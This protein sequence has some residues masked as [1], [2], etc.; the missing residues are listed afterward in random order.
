MPYLTANL[1]VVHL[2]KFLLELRTK[3]KPLKYRKDDPHDGPG[4]VNL[5]PHNPD[6][7]PHMYSTVSHLYLV[8]LQNSRK[9]LS[10]MCYLCSSYRLL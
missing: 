10:R 2:G 3:E 5:T 6:A 4:S 9:P 7:S 1:V 8:Y